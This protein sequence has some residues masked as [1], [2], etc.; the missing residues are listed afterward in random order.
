MMKSFKDMTIKWKLTLSMSAIAVLG[1]LG[2]GIISYITASE[3]V[4]TKAVH[5]LQVVTDLS[6]DMIRSTL[7]SSI[8]NHL[9]TISEKALQV[10]HFHYAQYQKGILSEQE[11]LE[12]TKALLLDSAYGKVGDTGYIAGVS[13]EGILAIHP[14]SEGI[15]AGQL[16]SIQQ[17]TALKNGYFEYMW[18][19]VG[20]EEEREKAAWLSYFEPWDLI[21]WASSYKDEFVSLIDIKDFR[22][23]LAPVRFGETGYMY[24]INF[25]GDAIIHPTFEGESAYDFQDA[26]TGHYITR[27]LIEKR[28]GSLT[29]Y[30]QNP[31]EAEARQ[32]IVVYRSLEEIDWILCSGVYTD[33]LFQE[34][35]SV[36]LRTLQVLLVFSGLALVFSLVLG[37]TITTPLNHLAHAVSNVSATNFSIRAEINTRD[38]VG[39]LAE[40]FNA[41]A[42]QLHESFEQLQLEIDQR[43]QIEETREEE[44]RDLRDMMTQVMT[45]AET[46]DSS[47]E[48][49]AQV[50]AQMA[51]KS[52]NM[53]QQV[54][55][56]SSNS[57]QIHQNIH[58]AS[59]ATEEV[60]ANIREIS[61][62]V[63]KVTDIVGH[64][65]GLTDSAQGSM[66][67]LDAQAH[68]IGNISKVITDIAQQT[69]LL[70][71]NATIEA[72]R[73]GESGKGFT[74][75]ANEV[76]SLAQETAGSADDISHKIET[77]QDSS[78]QTTQAIAKVVESIA[79]VKEFSSLFT[80]SMSQQNQTMTEISQDISNASQGS[81]Q[82]TQAISELTIEAKDS[83]ARAA[84]VLEVSG[85]LS[86][87]SDKLRKLVEK[88]K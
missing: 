5:E 36:N 9:R 31:G 54:S 27:E 28:N 1:I 81:S 75:V 74:V 51:A 25:Q 13:G 47:S 3:I 86:S 65:V 46:L 55:L 15:D 7:H 24:V 60:A 62:K 70:A 66:M 17:G 80:K 8:K 77:I 50:S 26:R 79:Q 67:S 63:H 69:N 44:L 11:A 6:H 14:K 83:A 30:W 33:E 71:L 53:S 4:K 45:I 61:G 57:R 32:K 68:Q 52:E 2:V 88:L 49:M 43:A 19:N 56:V 42:Q 59:T 72:A 76:K 82:I 38:E 23:Q 18:K 35:A 16:E 12:R 20:E 22:E 34:L 41:M 37:N 39:K 10:A 21:I 84:S 85:K 29:Y 58:N 40:A 73:A 48:E 64:A 87:T 78:R